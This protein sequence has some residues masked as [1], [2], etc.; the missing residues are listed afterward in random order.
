MASKH[1][2]QAK[3]TSIDKTKP[4]S[5][6]P[7]YKTLTVDGIN[8][9]VNEAAFEDMR[10][11]YIMGKVVND[12][13]PDTDRLRYYVD[14]LELVIVG[15]VYKLMNRLAEKKGGRLTPDEFNDFFSHLMDEA[16]AKN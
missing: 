11:V 5:V 1:K 16:N 12:S 8:L 14:L 10:T 6:Q 15:D 9:T 7:S 2:Q 13:A 3:L 4:R